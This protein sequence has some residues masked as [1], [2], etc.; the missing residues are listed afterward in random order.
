MRAHCS[1]TSRCVPGVPG[2][3]GTNRTR[4]LRHILTFHVTLLRVLVRLDVLGEMVRPHEPLRTDRTR[5]PLLPGVRPHVPLQLVGPGEPLP[6][7]EPAAQ[8]RPLPGVPPQMRL[9]MRRLT[10]HFV[11]PGVVAD[12]DLLRRGPPQPVLFAHAVGTLALYALPGPAG[13]VPRVLAHRHFRFYYLHRRKTGH[14]GVLVQPLVLL[15]LLGLVAARR[16]VGWGRRV[17]EPVLVVVVVR[18][19]RLV[20]RG[21][22][23]RRTRR[24]HRDLGDVAVATAGSRRCRRHLGVGER[25]R[26]VHPGA[27]RRQQVQRRHLQQTHSSK[28]EKKK[29][30]KK[31]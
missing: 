13:R 24:F 11:A 12:V 9:Q 7:E 16:D 28:K 15:L 6:A 20:V 30:M 5:K 29:Q 8:E 25:L 17:V 4:E 18:V 14:V 26:L 21:E 27:R 2:R 10:V 23:Q 1:K 31:K 19:G 22:L 3:F